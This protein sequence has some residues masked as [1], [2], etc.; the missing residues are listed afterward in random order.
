MSFLLDWTVI[1][2][3]MLAILAVGFWHRKRVRDAGGF[4]L[5]NRKVGTPMMI[6]STF[7]GGINANQPVSVAANSYTNGLSGM[8]LSLTF[9]L[10]TPFF[11]MWPPVL[12][13]LRIVTIVDF[14]RM[15]YGRQMEWLKLITMMIV[16]PF[17]LG[18]GI[19]AAAILVVAIGGPGADG[20]PAIGP[21]TAIMMIILPTLVYTLLGGV[22]AVY[23]VD[24]FQS[25]LIV[26]MSFLLLPFMIWKVGSSAEVIAR[27][28]AANPNVWDLIGS[29]QGVPAIWLVWFAISLFFSAPEVYGAGS[30]AARTEMASRWALIGNLGKRFCTLGWGFTGVFAIALLGAPAVAG[31]N[32]EDVFALSSLSALPAG[33]RGVMVA[34]MLATVMSTLANQMLLFGAC[35]VNNLYKNYVVRT[36]SVG[37]YLHMARLFTAL[38]LVAGWVVAA[39]NLGL[40]HLVV[41]TEQISGVLGVTIIGAL[42]WRKATSKGAIAAVLLMCPL[43]YYGNR[44]PAAWPDWYRW[45]VERVQA[46]YDVFGI[47]SHV[48]LVKLTEA[49]P[50]NLLQLTT[51]I[52]LGAGI[53]TLILV[54]L[55][56]SQHD[57]RAVAE[58]YARA[59]TPLGD[60]HKLRAAGYQADTI[61]DMNQAQLDAAPEDRDRSRRLLL[62]DLLTWPWLVATR[63]AR[64]SDYWVDFAGIAGS[65]LFIGG[66][67]W[68]LNLFTSRL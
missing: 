60:E 11:W 63:R 15:R 40:V 35:L 61:E 41:L 62:L 43:F 31:I 26:I 18:V 55:L 65:V 1:S 32:P 48:D 46:L 38:P 4:L 3:Y 50:E 6:A 28:E 45:M 12:R 14:F 49:R 42:I 23:A 16:A 29:T 47:S 21:Q 54:S 66:F 20:T 25:V 33:L 9:V 22:V 52:Y 67:F 68:L 17:T 5:G 24:M 19:K 30:G 10:A 44:P 2:L 56:S 8:W 53:L 39:S 27:A 7:A 64:L 34:A 58:F 36:A 13:R 37:H 57:E 59:E 51:P